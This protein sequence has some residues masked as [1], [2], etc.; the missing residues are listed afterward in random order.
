MTHRENQSGPA[1]DPEDG[2]NS[3]QNG[4]K[5]P[6]APRSRENTRSLSLAAGPDTSEDSKDITLAYPEEPEA[7][8]GAGDVLSARYRYR[9]IRRLGKGGF[10]SVF[11]AETLETRNDSDSPPPQVAVK[12]IGSARNPHARTSLKREL[13]ALLSIRHDR[14]PKLYDWS[15][16]GDQAFVVLQ[17][18]PAGSL[19]DARPFLGPFNE[20]QTWRLI[21]DL[22]SALS[23]AHRASILHLD[24]K[25]SNV[26]LDGNGGFVLTDFGVSHSSRMSKGL[27]HQG[28]IA[29]GLGTHG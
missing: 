21:T 13:A 6:E 20:E 26:L 10:G 7:S 16:E 23:A 25:P 28:Q 17:H 19:A 18:F 29:V 15:L 5:S 8:F 14:I 9:L 3:P 24:V 1:P 27:L 11:L 22:V 2:S 12:V 4:S